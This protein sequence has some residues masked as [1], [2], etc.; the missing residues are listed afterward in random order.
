MTTR[1]RPDLVADAP[2]RGG[3]AGQV[4][5]DD[6]ACLAG[7]GGLGGARRWEGKSDRGPCSD[8]EERAAGRP[9]RDQSPKSGRDRFSQLHA[10]AV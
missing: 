1:I 2:A 8:L 3:L 5:Q 4:D 9:V 6:R 7:F 10:D